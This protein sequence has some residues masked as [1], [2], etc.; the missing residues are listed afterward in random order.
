MLTYEQRMDFLSRVRPEKKDELLLRILKGQKVDITQDSDLFYQVNKDRVS[1]TEFTNRD[2]FKA[3]AEGMK[4][5][6]Q[7]MNDPRYGVS[8]G[9]KFRWL[10]DIPPEIYFSRK[11]FS[12]MIA[13]EERDANIRKWLN[14]FPV[15]KAGDKQV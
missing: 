5:D 8:K 1:L 4:K 6:K 10:G 9:G 13:K 15:F 2:K 3:A 7:V 12:P 11:E 14:Q